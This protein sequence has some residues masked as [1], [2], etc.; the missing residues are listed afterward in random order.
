MVIPGDGW[1]DRLPKDYPNLIILGMKQ[2]RDY[3]NRY[4][5]LL[6]W[7]RQKDAYLWQENDGEFE[8]HGKENI[9]LVEKREV[10]VFDQ[11]GLRF[12]V[13][14]RIYMISIFITFN[15]I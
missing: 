14:V 13:M 9:F 6:V 3:T 10:S 11:G 1:F 12:H 4:M 7:L 15:L 2:A 8:F 5:D